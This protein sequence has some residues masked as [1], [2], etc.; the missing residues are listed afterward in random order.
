MSN[1][2]IHTKGKIEPDQ[3]EFIAFDAP[4]YRSD[5]MNT[6]VNDIWENLS[7][8]AGKKGFPTFADFASHKERTGGKLVNETKGDCSVCGARP[9]I[10]AYFYHAPTNTY[11]VTG[12][13]CAHNILLSNDEINNCRVGFDKLKDDLKRLKKKEEAWQKKER[14]K[15]ELKQV[16]YENGLDMVHAFYFDQEKAEESYP[17]IKDNKYVGIARDIAKKYID[18][19]GKVSE[20]QWNF[21][22]KIDREILPNE[23][24][25]IKKQKEE[26]KN[27][28]EVP[29]VEERIELTGKILGT[30]WKETNYGEQ[31]KMLFQEDLGFKLWGTMPSRLSEED[32]GK[33]ITIRAKVKRSDKDPKFG[34]FNRPH[35]KWV[36][37]DN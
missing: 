1:Q 36:E 6:I 3:Y 5:D 23:I 26:E 12:Q 15:E 11:I 32:K 13:K 34:F 29:D 28:E 9:E 21:L 17:E 10:V 30:K 7:D 35:L 27:A 14:A 31:L 22:C 24:E 37:G 4:A 19:E 18:L 20:N 33:R 8:L 2:K 25:R 16:L